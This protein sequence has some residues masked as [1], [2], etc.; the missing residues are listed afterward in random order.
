MAERNESG[1]NEIARIPQD[2]HFPKRRN[3]RE[4]DLFEERAH[5]VPVFN[6]LLA[7]EIFSIRGEQWA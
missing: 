2:R 5:R 4:S 6:G 3:A 1:E 7:N